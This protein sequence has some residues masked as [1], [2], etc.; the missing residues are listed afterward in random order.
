MPFFSMDDDLAFRALK[1]IWIYFIVCVLLTSTTFAGSH[2]W[3]LWEKSINETPAS[4]QEQQGTVG[5]GG[6]LQPPVELK[7][8][9]EDLL[10]EALKDER[11]KNKLE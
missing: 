4:D 3:N 1:R 10:D 6:I 11:E 2:L 7:R 5:T 8:S 9:W